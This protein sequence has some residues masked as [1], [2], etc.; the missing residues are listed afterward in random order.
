[1]AIKRLI[2]LVW[3]HF[4]NMMYENT[5]R[6]SRWQLIVRLLQIKWFFSY[7]YATLWRNS[8][9]RPTII[10]WPGSQQWL[11]FNG[12][13]TVSR[14]CMC[15]W[16]RYINTCSQYP[17]SMKVGNTSNIVI[18]TLMSFTN[19]NVLTRSALVVKKHSSVSL[20]LQL[21]YKDI[22]CKQWVCTC[23]CNNLHPPQWNFS[24]AVS[25][26]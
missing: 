19:I 6:N 17:H 5:V 26:E 13:S 4:K 9:E 22:V 21:N 14:S 7:D 12:G 3:L 16:S 1:M 2:L 10:R 24:Q 15:W 18:L 20:A 23:T 11:L 8:I 25:T